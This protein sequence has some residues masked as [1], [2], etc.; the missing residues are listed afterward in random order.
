[1]AKTKNWI[2]RDKRIAI[3]LRDGFQC[4]Y[5]GASAEDRGVMLSLD[6]LICRSAGGGNNA[7]NLITACVAC[8]SRRRDT[9]LD[10]W[11][12]SIKDGAAI[13]TFIVEHT[14]KELGP[15]RKEAK[16]IIARRRS[17]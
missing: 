16:A 11:L 7:S 2:R 9:P 12:G 14:A 13:G 6:H 17:K 5:C 1:M 3:Y 10:Q 15:Y 4:A 8:N